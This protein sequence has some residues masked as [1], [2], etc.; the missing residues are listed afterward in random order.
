MR[1]YLRP[2]KDGDFCVTEFRKDRSRVE[3]VRK[4]SL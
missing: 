2:V 3:F 1:E 4:E